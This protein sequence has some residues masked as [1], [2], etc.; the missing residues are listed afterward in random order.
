M[1]YRG[2]P[3]NRQTDH[4]A[5]RYHPQ[6]Q[7]RSPAPRPQHAMHQPPAPQ[8]SPSPARSCCPR[9]PRRRAWRRPRLRPAPPRP[10]RRAPG[11]RRRSPGAGR[12]SR[13]ISGPSRSGSPA[14]M[15]DRAA[16][17][18]AATRSN[19]ASKRVRLSLPRP[20]HIPHR[21]LG[22]AVDAGVGDRQHERPADVKRL[23][24][25]PAHEVDRLTV[26]DDGVV[27]AAGRAVVEALDF[28][29]Q[30]GNVG[31]LETGS[32]KLEVEAG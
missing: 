13:S 6:P 16:S 21:D 17:T 18:T 24:R 31:G 27:D 7:S 30:R 9:G 19:S 3:L 28:V 32:W 29:D 8:C 23:R 12:G 2:S 5:L 26:D 14:A 4:S 11:M 25:L 10:A 20:P 22:R 1:E 15:A